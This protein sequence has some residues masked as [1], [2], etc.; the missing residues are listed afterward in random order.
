MSREVPIMHHHDPCDPSWIRTK[1]P[2]LLGKMELGWK[3]GTMTSKL[4]L[5]QWIFCPFI[6]VPL[7]T[8][9]GF[10]GNSDYKEYACNAGDLGLSQRRNSQLFL[11]PWSVLS[12]FKFSHSLNLFRVH[13]RY[14][15]VLNKT[16][17]LQLANL[18]YHFTCF[19][20]FRKV[21]DLV[22]MKFRFN[23]L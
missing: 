12:M 16:H 15:W 22:L 19:C 4:L 1:T 8:G 11:I 17:A 20:N 23:F 2:P 7:I 13:F 6:C 3:S 18:W 5:P 9:L 10:P 14:H 21:I